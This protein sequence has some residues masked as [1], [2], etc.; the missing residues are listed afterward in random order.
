MKKKT[1]MQNLI[2]GYFES[3]GMTPRIVM[4]VEN[5]EAIKSLVGVGL[6][7][8]IIP[9]CAVEELDAREPP[10][11]AALKGHA[12]D[13]ATGSGDFGRA[14]SFPRLSGNWLRLYRL[15]SA[16]LSPNPSSAPMIISE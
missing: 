11:G 1:A 9:R 14:T 7:A 5:N 13:A 2:D 10:S 6:G 15:R 12:V 3:I 8:S 16:L 4:E